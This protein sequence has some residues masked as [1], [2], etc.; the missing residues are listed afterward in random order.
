MHE[1][2][3]LTI[4]NFEL[5]TGELGTLFLRLLLVLIQKLFEV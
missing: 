3:D 4:L 2:L 5:L 1:E